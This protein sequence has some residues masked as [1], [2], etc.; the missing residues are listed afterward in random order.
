MFYEGNVTL[1]VN[2]ISL[3]AFIIDMLGVNVYFGG[4]TI[5]YSINFV[6]K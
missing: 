6:K 1:E 2:G 5:L 3:I 4:A